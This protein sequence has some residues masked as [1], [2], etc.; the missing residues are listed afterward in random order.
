MSSNL[1][2]H[3]QG[4]STQ[5]TFQQ[6]VV[7]LAKTIKRMGNPILDIFPD[8]VT[9]DSRN[10]TV[11]SVVTTVRNLEETG[12]KQYR[13]F[14]KNVVQEHSHSI[15]DPI[16]K[17]SL[18]PFRK[19]HC[20]TNSTQ[21]KEIK[22]LQNNVALFGQLYISM[23]N[24]DADLDEFFA[25]EIQSFPPSLS[26]FG[27][28][29]LPRMKPDLLQCF[30]VNKEV[31]PPAFC[32]CTVLDGAVIVHCLPVIGVTTFQQYADEVFI[33]YLKKQLQSSRRL[34]VVWDTYIADSLKES[35][36]ENRGKGVRMK[37]P[38][39]TKLP[40]NWMDFLCDSS[41]KKELF[42]LLTSKVEEF[43]LAI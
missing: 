39:E 10:C 5:K 28:L 4:P 11:E 19:P 21:G 27:K 24:R 23:H 17:N 8:L 9:L 16:K 41:N 15:H 32:D 36:R 31:E 14:V 1:C 12:K 35:T 38:G 42:A 25:H 13:D 37:V 33:P 30:K 43:N 3:E 34:D 20:K 22:V 40:R 2:H 26:D 6:Q 7:S 18:A 29:H